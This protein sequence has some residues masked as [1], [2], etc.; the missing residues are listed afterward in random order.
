MDL[1]RF[2]NQKKCQASESESQYSESFESCDL[3][4][5]SDCSET[6]SEEQEKT[7]I[8]V[9]N[10]PRNDCCDRGRRGPPGP[11]GPTG[12]CCT[13]PTGATGIVGPTG[14]IG[15]T[16]PCC[17][18]PTGLDGPT[19][20]T[21]PS[22]ELGP[23]G[24]SGEVGPTGP[25]GASGLEG[26]TGASGE[27]GPTGASGPRGECCVIPRFMNAISAVDQEVIGG[28]AVAFANANILIQPLASY[29]Q[30]AFNTFVALKAGY[31]KVDYN[32]N[33]A[34]T[35]ESSFALFDAVGATI[36]PR[37][38]FGGVG[39]GFVGGS[40][41]INLVANGVFSVINTGPAPVV[42][43]A[44]TNGQNVNSA[45]IVVQYLDICGDDCC[46]PRCCYPVFCRPCC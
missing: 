16:G 26:P 3:S 35:A 15:P 37:S 11:V 19:G 2:R 6:C 13:G 7:K 29:T 1:R 25:T 21:G 36:F 30:G 40:V 12:P 33:V 41:I 20:P 24:V 42:L 27:V 18:G 44:T 22:G 31:Y 17:T 38:A 4:N 46:E 45:S 14:D 32:L 34:S 28:A 5:C 8:I 43:S 39:P 23:T 9:I 10:G